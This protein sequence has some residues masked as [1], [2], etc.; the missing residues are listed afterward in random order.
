MSEQ[1][2]GQ[3]S[4]APNLPGRLKAAV[5]LAWGNK[6]RIGCGLVIASVAYLVLRGCVPALS[7]SRLPAALETAVADAYEHCDQ[8]FPIWPGEVRMP[9]CDTV[10]IRSVGAGEVPQAMRAQ[11]ITRAI[12]YHVDAEHM[13]WGEAGTQKHVMAWTL[14]TYSKVAVR[15]DGRWVLY[16]DEDEA[17]RDRWAE[18]E[19]PAEYEASSS[20]VPQ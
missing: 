10:T 11:G 4:P 6:G 7:G 16:P 8:D 19:C 13:F 15:Q 2:T 14:R 3:S 18:F 20:L 9:T 12:C 1:T 17:D 5:R